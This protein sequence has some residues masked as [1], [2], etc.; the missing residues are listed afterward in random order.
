MSTSFLFSGIGCKIS[1]FLTIF[2]SQ[3]SVFLLCLL[4]VERW[5]AI[6]MALYLNRFTFRRT[7]LITIIG[8]LYAIIMATLPL[9][10][11]SSYTTTRYIFQFF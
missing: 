7:V 8:W 5:Y 6:K 4:T 9:I 3:L 2:S 1:G 11:I 10:G